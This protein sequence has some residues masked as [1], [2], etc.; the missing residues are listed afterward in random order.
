MA[1]NDESTNQPATNGV[2]HHAPAELFALT[3]TLWDRVCEVLRQRLGGDNFQRC[4][5]GT[6]GRLADD[7]R[8]IITVPNPIHQL[9]I[10]SNHTAA[11]ADAV[12][13]VTGVPAVIEFHVATEPVPASASVCSDA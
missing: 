7:G 1:R 2:N 12:A 6:S 11:V 10:E 3:P 4:F 9:W 13:E 8:F 5:S